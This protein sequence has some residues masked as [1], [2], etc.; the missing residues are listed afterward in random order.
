VTGN[1]T[2]HMA[3]ARFHGP[4]GPV[5]LG[6]ATGAAVLLWVAVARGGP[7]S[8]GGEARD[9]IVF[10]VWHVLYDTQ[11]PPTGVV[12]A[13]F[14]LALL[15][16]A[17]VAGLERRIATR[18]HWSTDV[19]HTPLAPRLVMAATAGV[20]A[21]PVPVTVLI[22][23]HDEEVSL[24]ATIDSL[25]SQSHRPERVI[26]VAD[27]CTDS[28]VE[29]ARQRGVEVIESV[30]NV[31]KKAGALNQAMAQVLPTLG[32]NDT[33]MV[34]DADTSLDPGFLAVAG[35]QLTA[36]RALMAVGGLFYGD[37][38]PGLLAQFQR[39]E[40][41]RYGREIR[42]RRGFV[43]VLT[44]TASLFRARALRTIADDRGGA[45]PGTRG[46]V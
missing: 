46:A 11:A 12:V 31:H 1:G 22:S 19:R 27:N 4:V 34:M 9:G 13:A 45:I 20:H 6:V 38:S 39:N 37:R 8:V 26:I 18:S 16:A 24:G 36:D 23:A 10:G 33:V 5:I 15:F 21:G 44:G 42:R 14:A 30:G 35:A 32:D 25:L 43:F 17:G 29:I 3:I 2:G 41:V 40:Y 7:T 28:T